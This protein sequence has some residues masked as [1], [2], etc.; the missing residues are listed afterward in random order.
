MSR[1]C[2]TR[3]AFIRPVEEFAELVLDR[4][5]DRFGAKETPMLA[6]GIDLDSGEP[7]R[8]E[9]LPTSNL[10]C[11]QN[12]L[13][14]LE[15]LTQ[16]TGNTEWR[17]KAER[18]IDHALNELTDPAS[19]LFYWGG[20]STWNLDSDKP[21]DGN[22]ELK[23]VYPHYS[24]LHQ[25]APKKTARFID[26][27]WHQHVWDWETLLFNR[28]GDYSDWER[29]DAWRGA[30]K[31]GQLPII[32][33][34]ALSF[35]NTGSDLIHAAAELHRLGGQDEPLLWAQ[36]LLSRY[37]QIRHPETR[38][39]GYQFNHSELCRVRESFKGEMGKRE[40]VNETT[41]IHS[42]VI[43]VRYGRAAITFMNIAEALGKE[44]GE[45][46][47]D[48]VTNDLE[49]L[50]KHSYDETNHLF[51]SV[52][53][54]GEKLSPEDTME[55]VGYCKPEKLQPVNANGLMFL[56]YAR[57]F[58]LTGNE[59]F[60]LM[61]EKLAEGMGLGDLAGPIHF[62][63]ARCPW[64]RSALDDACALMGL[65]EFYA[66]TEDEA[67]MASAE[68][69]GQRVLSDYVEDR[70]FIE[71]EQKRFTRIDSALP[72]ALLHLAAAQEGKRNDVPAFYASNVY[73]DPKVVRLKRQKDST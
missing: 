3:V 7:I 66:A 11:Q 14:V 64:R 4:C 63:E 56:S 58:R 43:Q 34:A 38:L 55:G 46:F 1:L 26:A 51:S 48:F 2:A 37:N 29:Q 61:V 16:L 49:A 30:F 67:L 5:Q 21:L 9:G 62:D 35:I 31:G 23:C 70:F 45:P 33:R 41:V 72:L 6:D 8:W 15:G 27:F 50:A 20:H 57:A 65:L 24:F 71:P 42:Q 69:L 59:I 36:H 73:W 28:H 44:K 54:N 68:S 18:W 40:D 47:L 19:D 10:A 12:F 25:V 53:N 60:R 52:L 22:H 17:E 32:D 39:G 13:R